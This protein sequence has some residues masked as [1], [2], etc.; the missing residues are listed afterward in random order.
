MSPAASSVLTPETAALG[1]AIGLL[2]ALICYLTTNLS[3]GGMIS[4]AG[5]A[6]TLVEDWRRIIVIACVVALTWAGTVVVQRFVILYGKRLFAGALMLG[7]F[8]QVTLFA[9]V[10]RRFP[11]LLSHETL[12]FLVPGLIA[13]H[14]VRQPVVPTLISTTFVTAVTYA[15]LATGILL[16]LLGA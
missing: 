7:I 12:V 5:L 1:F 13:Y 6:I 15:V 3:P 4:P 14:L 16:H 11:L 9:F 10:L 2:F 8:L